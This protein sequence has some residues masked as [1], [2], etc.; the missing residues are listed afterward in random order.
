M[1][2]VTRRDV[3]KFAVGAGLTLAM[4]RAGTA[5]AQAGEAKK[6]RI[7]FIG[8]GDRG[9][10]LLRITLRLPNVEVPAVC[11][12]VPASAKRAQDLVEK[13]LGKRPESYENGPTNYRRLLE[14]GD[15][16]A[17]VL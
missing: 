4:S 12:I 9:T 14:R 2:N 11:D 15:V 13:A 7:G 3:M 6:V 16:D 5:L 10:G 17:V 8:V 1:N